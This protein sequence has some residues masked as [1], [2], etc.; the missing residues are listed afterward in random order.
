MP[1]RPLLNGAFLP[2]AIAAGVTCPIIDAEKMK[3]VVLA[4]DVLLNRDKYARRYMVFYRQKQKNLQ[5]RD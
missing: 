3:A 2:L 4:T 1:D 5:S